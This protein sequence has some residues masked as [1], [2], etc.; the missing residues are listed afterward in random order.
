MS[1]ELTQHLL[2][3]LG[4]SLCDMSAYGMLM[5]TQVFWCGA[6]CLRTKDV[7]LY[8]SALDLSYLFLYKTLDHSEM[9]FDVITSCAPLP[10]GSSY[11]DI[12]MVEK[13]EELLSIVPGKMPSPEI[14][15][16]DFVL[17]VIKGL[18]Q[19]RTFVRAVRVLAIL[20]P[21]LTDHDRWND[22]QLSVLISYALIPLALAAVKVGSSAAIGDS[23]ARSIAH[24][25]AQG[26]HSNEPDLT[27][28]LAKFATTKHDPRGE[29]L[30]SEFLATIACRQLNAAHL[31]AHCLREFSLC[32]DS[33]TAE[34]IL[35]ILSK[36]PKA[37][38]S[39]N[40]D[41]SDSWSADVAST[42]SEASYGVLLSARLETDNKGA[43]PSCLEY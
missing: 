10:R 29:F 17:L 37:S 32:A 15:W 25:L 31:P 24:R 43:V 4:A 6:M 18:F 5:Y 30:A 11:P 3:T 2:K 1:K 41:F 22:L 23:E 26:L 28:A 13:Y 7:S 42:I 19:A 8:S 9:A 16:A 14:S 40:R 27:K 21:Y 36:A 39:F 12:P 35:Q 38:K 33:A 20:A 34:T